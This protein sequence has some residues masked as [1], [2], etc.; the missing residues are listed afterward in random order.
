MEL[1]VISKAKYDALL[2]QIQ[3]LQFEIGNIHS[4]IALAN[5]AVRAMQESNNQ[6]ADIAFDENKFTNALLDKVDE[7]AR[8][9]AKDTAE[10]AIDIDNLAHEVCNQMDISEDVA[11]HVER[12]DLVA[13]DDVGDIVEDRISSYDYQTESEVEALLENYLS[14]NHYICRDDVEDVV[15][16]AVNDIVD[17]RTEN[18]ARRIAKEEIF[19]VIHQMMHAVAGTPQLIKENTNAND[20]RD[21]SIQVSGI[22][23][24]GEARSYNAASA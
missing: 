15:R 7:V 10:D 18:V 2:A 8:E 17:E 6:L 4:Q 11:R 22:D 16:D 5:S 9:V 12:L 20:S 24:Q 14:D 13:T 23:G 21:T 3:T 1:T 19:K